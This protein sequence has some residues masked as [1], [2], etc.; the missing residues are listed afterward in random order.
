MDVVRA[1]SD[2]LDQQNRQYSEFKKLCFSNIDKINLWHQL[3]GHVTYLHDFEQL[4][5]IIH[6]PETNKKT[7]FKHVEN[8]DLTMKNIVG[9]LD[10]M[11]LASEC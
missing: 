1:D 2:N 4:L 6:L 9:D 5:Q 10:N 11:Y 7:I 3:N 8:E